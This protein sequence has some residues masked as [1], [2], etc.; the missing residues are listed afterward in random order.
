MNTT[1]SSRRTWSILTVFALTLLVFRDVLE[2]GFLN[3]DD[4]GNYV[5]NLHYRG[6]NAEN[7]RWIFSSFHLGVWQ[8]LSW[9]LADLEWSFWG[10]DPA[11]YHLVSLLLHASNASLVFVFTR[12]LLLRIHLTQDFTL[13]IAALAGTLFFALHPL[14]VEIVAW[15]SCQG[16]LLCIF[17]CLLSLIFYT[18]D[19]RPWSLVFFAAALMSKAS[20]MALPA[21]LI[22]L[23]VYP[24]R[25]LP[26]DPRHWRDPSALHVLQEKIPFFLLSGLVAAWAFY[27][28]STAM[29]SL[30]HHGW[31]ERLAQSSYGL[32]FYLRKTLWPSHLSPL[33]PMPATVDPMNLR[34]AGSFVIFLILAFML[35]R[36][37]RV[38]PLA[39]STALAAMWLVLPVIGLA[40]VGPQIAADRYTCLPAIFSS[41]L[42]ADLLLRL[43][44][45]AAFLLS[46]LFLAT[47]AALSMQR[48]PVWRNSDSLWT[49]TLAVSAPSV[50]ACN[51]LGNIRL[52]QERWAEA[53]NLYRQSLQLDPQHHE[54]WN[55]L[56]RA[57]AGL[58]KLR[59]AL[60]AYQHA[61]QL[62]PGYANAW[63]NAGNLYADLH[64]PADAIAAYRTAL[65]HQ[66]NHVTARMNLG[67]LLLEQKQILE[68]IRCFDQVLQIR[69]D[70]PNALY[71]LAWIYAA[72]PDPK[73]RNALEALRLASRLVALT[74]RQNPQSL[75]ALAAAQAEAGQFY[76]ASTT[77]K[78]ALDLAE[79]L[80]QNA[81]AQEIS[82]RL[83]FY[84]KSKPFQMPP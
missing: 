77:A 46:I 5:Q 67:L 71:A 1:P 39:L 68:A 16:Y 34:F 2:C 65:R 8:P 84:Q 73:L 24:L 49:R 17:F 22:V 56:G 10:M 36:G 66:P 72:S 9:L 41:V 20:C 57:L 58:G 64:Q 43:R 6:W 75:D 78:A 26:A 44:S 53:T 74:G 45:R 80:G 82:Q 18:R 76:E 14:R 52:E 40:Q 27:G 55:S 12:Q 48:V 37:R 47:L 25:R 35:W 51:N 69:A 61:L 59:E 62:N 15:L 30:D 13:N 29:S 4:E 7:L 50:T 31:V 21:A 28:K 79:Q 60:G 70:H 42:A 81:L 23:D 83:A 3:W 32:I 33:Y 54:T 38:W 19:H 11:A 63:L